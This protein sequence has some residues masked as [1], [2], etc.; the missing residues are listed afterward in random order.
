M[1]K[2]RRIVQVVWGF[3][4]WAWQNRRTAV[5]YELTVIRDGQ[6]QDDYLRMLFRAQRKW[7]QLMHPG[8]SFGP[9]SIELKTD[10]H[11]VQGTVDIDAAWRDLQ[12][13]NPGEGLS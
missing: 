12:R 1:M 7:L 2:R 13:R 11:P 4:T 5:Q 3:A 10:G 8:R 9:M 6:E